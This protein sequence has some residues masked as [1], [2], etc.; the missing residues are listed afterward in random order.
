M[1][2][3]T[4][5]P[6]PREVRMLRSLRLLCVSILVI[7]IATP[8][9]A[10]SLVLGVHEHASDAQSGDDYGASVATAGGRVFVGADF[11]FGYGA[12]YVL[13]N[14]GGSWIEAQEIQS[15]T[16]GSFGFAVATNGPFLF[17]GVP[18]A[19]LAVNGSGGVLVYERIAGSWVQTGTLTANDAGTA[20]VFGCSLSCTSTT[21]VVGA[22]HATGPVATSGAAY[23]FVLQGSTWT[24]Q[25]KLIAPDGIANAAFG[26]SVSISGDTI[27]AGAAQQTITFSN[28]GA[29]Y[30]YVRNGTVWTL[31]AEL[32]ASNASSSDWFGQLVALDGDRIA[33]TAPFGP[34]QGAGTG[35]T[36]VFER[37]GTTWSQVQS[38]FAPDASTTADYGLVG[39]AMRDDHLLIGSPRSTTDTSGGIGAVYSYRRI[40]GTWVLDQRLGPLGPASLQTGFGR[41]CAIADGWAVIGADS[42]S[43]LPLI[44]NGAAY[45]YHIDPNVQ[46]YCFGD[47]AGSA[48]PCGDS[49]LVAQGRGCRNSTSS[50]ARLRPEGLASVLNDTLRLVGEQMPASATAL[51]FQGTTEINLGIGA[52]FGDG[53]RCAGGSVIRLGYATNSFGASRYPGPS[54]PSVSVKGAIPAGGGVER[55]YQVWFRDAAQWCTPSL[56]NLSNAVDVVWTP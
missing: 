40:G 52:V 35:Q 51:Y 43:L 24:Q 20:D 48:C 54:D 16:I 12:V 3:E 19:N 56:F 7:A 4:F 41:S 22:K 47:G 32:T 10:Q 33:A 46:L 50:G 36:Y 2:A 38:F 17:V 30:V 49:G 15:P 21:L 31:Q 11:H 23:V 34:G 6:L 8:A 1:A 55:T 5:P 27:C 9:W 26:S 14:T 29:A 53:L 45:V 18:Q 37:S 42:E 13:E 25:A 44:S 28:Q 39:L